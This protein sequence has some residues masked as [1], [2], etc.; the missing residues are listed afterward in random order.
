MAN[1]LKTSCIV[2]NVK[3]HVFRKNVFEK[4][5]DLFLTGH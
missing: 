2:L 1:H 5:I 3:M 4:K